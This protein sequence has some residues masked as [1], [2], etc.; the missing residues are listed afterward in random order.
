MAAVGIGEAADGV[1]GTRPVPLTGAGSRRVGVGVGGIAGAG[2][3]LAALGALVGGGGLVTA[4][5]GAGGAA[6]M[7]FT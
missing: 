5:G 2:T 6:G 7:G 4:G 3:G 1:S